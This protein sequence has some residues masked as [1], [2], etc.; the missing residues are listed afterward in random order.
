MIL[1][2]Q[3][4]A[5]PDTAQK[6]ELN[7]W[8]RVAQY[9]YNW[10]LGD[11]FQWWEQS[12]N[13]TLPV[14]I[15]QSDYQEN[16]KL[17]KALEKDKESGKPKKRKQPT[18][19]VEAPYCPLTCSLPPLAPRDNPD[20]YSQKKLLPIK[21]KDLIKVGHS[22][23]LLDFFG[24]PSQTLQDVTQRADRAFKRY[25]QGDAKGKRSGK[26]RFKN[27]KSYRTLKIEGQAVD[28][29][30]I[31]KDW[32]FI[33]ISKLKGWLKIRRHRPLPESFTLKN[34]LLTKKADG[35]YA[36]LCLEDPTVPVFNPDDVT[37][38]WENSIG[39]DA[40]L[41][42]DDYLATS[43]G[44]KLPSL[45]SFRKSQS[46]LAKV[47]RRKSARKRGDK[48]RRLLAK[49]EAREH[50]RIARARKDHAYNTAKAL[51]ATGKKVFFVEDLD[52]K[53]LTKRNKSKQDENGKYLP[54]G[55]SAKSGLNKSWLDA[56]FGQF[57]TILEDKAWKAGA[58]VVKVKPDY[59]S[60]LLCY[61]DE[62]VFT[63]CSIR[64]W[65]D[66]ELLLIIDRDI[67]AAINIKRV[68]LG[69]F[70]TIN[71]R[72]ENLVIKATETD[73]TLKEILVVL[74]ECQK[75]TLP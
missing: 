3:Y 25:I 48:G 30:R 13:E 18:L 34:V 37:P 47:S 43:E 62:F 41:H 27:E 15:W 54:N 31:E 14:G 44:T 71:R 59:T 4:R 7:S 21:K 38:T 19:S 42:E 68:V 67:N 52:L 56:A 36:T 50:Q 5:Y 70:P 49:R 45:K 26:P 74:S 65:F 11:R 22:G 75:P 32:F 35:W 33:C 8:R 17:Y 73:S 23:E 10:Q 28:I 2:Y 69:V 9:W 16:F 12:R 6:L 40:V 72:K 51:I 60:Q 1:N 64:E 61:R 39:L 55:Q 46:R 58:R 29:E 53:S 24:L 63:D 20:F 57:L 66:R